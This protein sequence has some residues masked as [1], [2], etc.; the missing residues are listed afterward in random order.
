MT[1]LA[2]HIDHRVAPGHDAA[3][4]TTLGEI[5]SRPC[6]GALSRVGVNVKDRNKG[7]R[8][9]SAKS[10]A[11]CLLA[12]DSEAAVLDSGRPGA[13]IASARIW[14]G[15]HIETYDDPKPWLASYVVIPLDAAR[16]PALEDAFVDL[17]TALS[18]VAGYVAVER[19]YGHAHSAALSE[20]PAQGEV[21]DFPRRA[22]ERKGHY[23]YDKKID[24]QIGG[25]DWGLILGP[26][27]LAR[28]APD[29]AVFVHVRD[30]GAA[31]LVFLS[32]DPGDAVSEAFD[33]RLEAARKALAPILM[34]TT[35]VPVA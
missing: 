19:D 23:W 4:A 1:T 10:I 5:L 32:R 15:R 11:E 26:G 16:W 24:A 13:L 29:P 27:H 7:H 9:I 28:V 6:F 30:A 34:D 25:P 22:Q 35:A 12:P 18:A 3:L 14:T 20:A 2:F 8:E 31:K 33:S 21:R 17:T